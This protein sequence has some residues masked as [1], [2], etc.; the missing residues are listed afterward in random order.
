M[1]KQVL[2][3]QVRSQFKSV[4]AELPIQ[5]LERQQQVAMVEQ[6]HLLQRLVPRFQQRAAAVVHQLH[7]LLAQ[8]P[9]VQL[10][11]MVEADLHGQT[12]IQ[13]AQM[14]LEDIRAETR[15]QMAALQ[16]LKQVAVVVVQVLREP[17][18]LVVQVVQVVSVFQI[19]IR[20]PRFFMVAV[21]VAEKELQAE[22]LVQAAM[23][24][25]VQAE[26]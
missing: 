17:M 23:V 24:V 3:F 20:A 22:H 19:H 2:L 18:Q 8:E 5:Q 15:G 21:A 9:Q 13:T 16:I 1:L 11:L 14:V 25:V 10:V 6:L 4:L 7:H 26:K 12:H